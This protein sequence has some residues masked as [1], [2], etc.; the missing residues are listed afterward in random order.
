M[1]DVDQYIDHM[2]RLMT[3]K[4]CSY[5]FECELHYRYLIDR[6][7]FNVL[8]ITDIIPTAIL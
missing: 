8:L 3:E 4:P 2:A 5:G 7:G 1:S 6:I